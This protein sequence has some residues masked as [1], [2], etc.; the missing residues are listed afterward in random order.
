M[1]VLSRKLGQ[2]IFVPQLRMIVTVVALTEGKV[3]LGFSAPPEVEIYREEVAN[4][5]SASE[6]CGPREGTPVP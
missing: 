3:R 5:K 6:P 2:R 1:L 4:Q